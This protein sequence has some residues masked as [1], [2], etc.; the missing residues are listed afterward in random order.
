MESRTILGELDTNIVQNSRP[1]SLVVS[2]R[3][4]PKLSEYTEA[5]IEADKRFLSNCFFYVDSTYTSI[6]SAEPKLRNLKQ[7]LA[8]VGATQCNFFSDKVTLIISSR[9]FSHTTEYASNDIFARVD[10]EVRR[11]WSYRRARYALK[12][13][14]FGSSKKEHS[15]SSLLKSESGAK[16]LVG[17][18]KNFFYVY[19][20]SGKYK[21]IRLKE[22]EKDSMIPQMR[23]NVRGRSLFNPYNHLE[24]VIEK[25]KRNELEN[26]NTLK[27]E[28]ETLKK[29][30]EWN[31]I[32]TGGD[33]DDYQHIGSDFHYDSAS[34]VQLGES[35]IT[36]RLSTNVA[37]LVKNRFQLDSYLSRNQ[38]LKRRIVETEMARKKQKKMEP[39]NTK[40][41]LMNC[42]NCRCYFSDLEKHLQ[43]AAHKSFA[44]NNANYAKIDSLIQEIKDNVL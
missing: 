13:M 19:D 35:I 37:D 23:G 17:F 44:Q 10:G 14:G 38:G 31:H 6:K 30:F 40:K 5:S 21:A 24:Q 39:K 9:E 36:G 7:D 3:P 4:R 26:K 32:Q 29:M 15:L 1:K 27:K 20:L 28:R 25:W 22:W 2:V 16:Q 34:G 42:E 8:K 18:K 33:F 11:V 41:K 12:K 43:S